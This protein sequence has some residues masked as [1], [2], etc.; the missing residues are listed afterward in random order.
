MTEKTI[1][2]NRDIPSP[3]LLIIP[4]IRLSDIGSK[5]PAV[6]LYIIVRRSS[7]I[8][9]EMHIIII[10]I[11]PSTPI[12]FFTTNVDVITVSIESVNIPPTTGTNLPTAY[13]IV[14]SA[15]P[16]V[17]DEV[18]PDILIVPTKK[19]IIAAIAQVTACLENC[20]SFV[21]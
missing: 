7:F 17:I 11:T 16:S 14:L 9:G 4:T 8:I 1:I 21:T 18:I 20:I 5:M 13:Y 2:N 3:M 6:S 19:V 12:A 15:T 10:T